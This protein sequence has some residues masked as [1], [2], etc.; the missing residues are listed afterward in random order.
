MCPVL[1]TLRELKGCEKNIESYHNISKAI[2]L[3]H[4]T[5]ASVTE[6]AVLQLVSVVVYLY[7][8]DG[9]AA[10]FHQGGFILWWEG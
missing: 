10:V 4:E 8:F 2:S 9:H 5:H 6:S 1:I 3:Q 7:F